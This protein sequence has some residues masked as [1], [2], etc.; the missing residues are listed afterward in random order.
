MATNIQKTLFH[1]PRILFE[2]KITNF[3][4]K[5]STMA[6]NLQRLVARNGISRQKEFVSP[7]NIRIF[8]LL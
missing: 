7:Q 4:P 5:Q 2:C 6:T 1:N 3:L 8:V